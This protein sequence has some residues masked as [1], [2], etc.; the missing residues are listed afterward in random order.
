[1]T[2]TAAQRATN[3]VREM[4]TGRELLPGQQMRQ[5]EL[6]RSLGLSRS[7]LREALRALESEGLVR[8]VPNQGYFVS[9]LDADELRQVYLMRRLLET[10]VLRSLPRQSRDQLARLRTANDLVATAETTP[11]ALAANRGFHFAIFELSPLEL[12]V[13][14]VERLWTLSEPYQAAYLLLPE[15]RARIV[16]EHGALIRALR[17]HDLKQLVA[18]ANAHR[19]ASERAVL[20]LL[21][22]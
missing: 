14:H 3:V 10:D 15:T 13:Q 4:I 11:D 6:S 18:V 19:A 8:H 17:Q 21:G 22:S 20:T 7:P 16:R 5:E 1:V 2:A 9:R 12:V